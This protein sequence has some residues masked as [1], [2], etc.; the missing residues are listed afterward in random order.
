MELRSTSVMDEDMSYTAEEW[1]EYCEKRN[2]EI[3]QQDALLRLR[4]A[5]FE[6][7]RLEELQ[8][9]QD[10]QRAEDARRYEEFMRSRMPL[11]L[12]RRRIEE[13]NLTLIPQPVEQLSCGI[14]WL[15][16]TDT[17]GK[18]PRLTPRKIHKIRSGLSRMIAD[19]AD[20][21]VNSMLLHTYVKQLMTIISMPDRGRPITNVYICYFIKKQ[22]LK[23]IYG[24]TAE[25][26]YCITG[27]PRVQIPSDIKKALQI[28][29]TNV[30]YHS[31][32]KSLPDLSTGDY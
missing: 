1:R 15:D 12:M 28:K 14:C 18:V 26:G 10:I 4:L 8:V 13:I 24:N 29:R 23:I 11:P 20:S 5:E 17:F 30:L 19:S 22:C 7:T 31:P 2:K 9:Q 3:R 21:V 25:G 27:F 32:S 16:F 6:R